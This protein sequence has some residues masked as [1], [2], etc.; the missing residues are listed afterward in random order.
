MPTSLELFKERIEYLQWFVKVKY[1]DSDDEIDKEE[2][3]D[4]EG[5]EE[6][7]KTENSF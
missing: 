4:F 3:K 7:V 2:V 6:R 5:S 1:E